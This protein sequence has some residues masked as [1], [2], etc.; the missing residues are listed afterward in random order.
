MQS[1]QI[2]GLSMAQ[3]LLATAKDSECRSKLLKQAGVSSLA[4]G[5]QVKAS[6][7]IGNIIL[8]A[9]GQ[10]GVYPLDQSTL[11][12]PI[13]VLIRWN[14]AGS[15][16]TNIAGNASA[17]PAAFDSVN[18][19][20]DTLDLLNSSFSVRNAMNYNPELSYNIPGRYLNSVRH[21]IADFDPAVNR[22][23]SINL[24]SAPSGMLTAI[25]LTLKPSSELNSA[26]SD[27][28][29]ASAY[30]PHFGSINL[31]EIRLDYGGTSLWRSDSPSENQSHYRSCFAGDSLQY[32]I[33]DNLYTGGAL[34]AA[35]CKYE[36]N[37][38]VI[39]LGY[40]MD[41][42]LRGHL[43]E[44]N[45]SYSGATLSLTFRVNQLKQRTQYLAAAPFAEVAS[46]VVGSGGAIPFVLEVCYVLSSILEVSA[47]SVDL[48][49]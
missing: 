10:E 8:N 5:G 28:G 22:E 26:A 2:S 11:S 30:D 35:K 40:D 29:A 15:F 1:I 46:T 4:V 41:K 6:V 27:A 16:T 3:Y 32:D 48:Q 31:R 23:H 43:V 42:S 44:N 20:V 24:T 34:T 17:V 21:N 45:A 25:I 14:P 9:L 13:Q 36:Q 38:Y 37:V 19:T 12:G 39:P 49:L 33:E 47:G 18:M 7:P